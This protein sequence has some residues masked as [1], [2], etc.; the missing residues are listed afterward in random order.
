MCGAGGVGSSRGRGIQEARGHQL[1]ITFICAPQP[2]QELVARAPQPMPPPPL[3]P[4]HTHTCTHP[5]TPY[6]THL[7][8]REHGHGVHA[9]PGVLHLVTHLHGAW[10]RDDRVEHSEY[11]CVC[12]C[13]GSVGCSA[14]SGSPTRM[15]VMRMRSRK[16]SVQPMV[17]HSGLAHERPPSAPPRST[18][19]WQGARGCGEEAVGSL[20]LRASRGVTVALG[21]SQTSQHINGATGSSWIPPLEA[22]P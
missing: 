19:A 2:T 10:R 9:E 17:S 20:S 1:V 22:A 13:T 15:T 7:L 8:L 21:T 6:F 3:P 5:H 14:H 12:V 16:A 11:A 18:C 4:G